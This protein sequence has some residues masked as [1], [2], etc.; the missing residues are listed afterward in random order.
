LDA[1][2]RVALVSHF[3]AGAIMVKTKSSETNQLDRA[4]GLNGLSSVVWNGTKYVAPTTTSVTIPALQL[5][6]TDSKVEDFVQIVVGHSGRFLDPLCNPE[7]DDNDKVVK[8]CKDTSAIIYWGRGRMAEDSKNKDAYL[9]GDRFG[10]AHV[11]FNKDSINVNFYN[12][13]DAAAEM[14]A[15]LT[16]PKS[17]TRKLKK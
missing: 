16:L 9:A 12:N 13:K 3:H 1:G 14:S 8:T 2:I 11:V 6:S 7:K 5:K 15:T 10:F 4:A 17:K